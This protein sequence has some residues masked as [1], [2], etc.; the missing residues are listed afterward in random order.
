MHR[1]DLAIVGLLA[2]GLS[3]IVW[4]NMRSRQR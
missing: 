1:F 4:R 3:W 2:L